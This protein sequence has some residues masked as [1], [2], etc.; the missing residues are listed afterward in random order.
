MIIEMFV[1][2]YKGEVIK[3]QQQE[4]FMGGQPDGEEERQNPHKIRFDAHLDIINKQDKK[5]FG[6]KV[7]RFSIHELV[8]APNMSE[9]TKKDPKAKNMIAH[10][11][12]PIQEC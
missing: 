2:E 12:H 5:K 11:F 10:T 9:N 8:P 7:L 4:S 6:D 1:R 3:G